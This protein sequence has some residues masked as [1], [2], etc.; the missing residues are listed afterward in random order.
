MRK[1]LAALMAATAIISSGFLYP[2]TMVITEI[3]NDVVTLETATGFVYQFEGA[4]D[5][6]VKDM[7]SLIMFTNGTPEIMD[8]VILSARYSGFYMD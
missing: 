8:D 3:E 1:V 6:A 2:T 4:E 5:Y 7:V